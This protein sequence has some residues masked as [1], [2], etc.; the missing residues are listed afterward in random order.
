MSQTRLLLVL[1]V[2]MGVSLWGFSDAN[3]ENDQV[4]VVPFSQQNIRLPH[5]AHEGAPITLKAIIRNAQCGSYEIRWDINQNGSY[6]DDYSFTANR[7]NNTRTVRDIGRAFVVP[8]VDRDKPM[9][10]N[11]ICPCGWFS[12]P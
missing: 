5:P 6:D 11:V 7:D 4:I 9:N 1:S 2:F 10:I 3:A 8:Y 12:L